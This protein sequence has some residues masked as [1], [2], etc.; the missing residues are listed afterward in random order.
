MS[1]NGAE[2]KIR[3][4]VAEYGWHAIKVLPKGDHQPHTYSIGLFETFG[5][6]EIAIVGLRGETAHTFIANIVDEIR[7]GRMFAKLVSSTRTL[8]H[9][10]RLR[11]CQSLSRSTPSTSDG[12]CG[13]TA[14]ESFPSCR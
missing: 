8:L 2:S 5:H 1:R 13:T 9:P 14:P 4:D 7:G 6:P 12:R 10:F 11:S 3:E